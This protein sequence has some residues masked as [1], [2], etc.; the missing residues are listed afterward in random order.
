MT[1]LSRLATDLQTWNTMEFAFVELP[2][3]FSSV[4]SIMPQKKN[5][6]GLEFTKAAAAQVTGALT[7][8]LA[9]SKNTSFSDVNDGVTSLNVP[10]LEACDKTRHV[11][12]VI[13]GIVAN[14]TLK[15]ERMQHFAEIGYGTATELAD[16]IVRETGLSFRMAHN[17]VGRIVRDAIAAG[18]TAQ[19]I[20]SQELDAAAQALF[21][22]SLGIAPDI[23][24]RA[25]DPAENVRT[26][27]V[28]GGPAP[29]TVAEMIVRRRQELDDDRANIASIESRVS[30]ALARLQE[31]ARKEAAA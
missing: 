12:A 29:D 28:T 4:S 14:M 7:T 5:P 24:A 15:P 27:N 18:R 2:D 17:I 26:R 9:S 21:G 23:V 22:Q 8:A 13:D 25:L 1:G 20:T 10:V 11:L 3:A 31:G 16:I 6:Q 19:T 30:S